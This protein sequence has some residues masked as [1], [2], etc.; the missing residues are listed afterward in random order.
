[1]TGATNREISEQ[2]GIGAETVK[3]L[4]SRIYG[5][6]GVKRRAEAVAVA[7]ELGIC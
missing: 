6:L 5:K 7:H 4:V 1:M 2:L 3:T